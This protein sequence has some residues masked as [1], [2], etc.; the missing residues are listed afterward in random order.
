VLRRVA[1]R[2]KGH[3]LGHPTGRTVLLPVNTVPPCGAGTVLPWVTR[4]Y[5]GCCKNPCITG[6]HRTVMYPETTSVNYLLSPVQLSPA[7]PL[8]C[9]AVRLSLTPP[10][11]VRCPLDSVAPLSVR[12]VCCAARRPV[13][14]VT[15]PVALPPLSHGASP[16]TRR[17]TDV[18]LRHAAPIVS[19]YIVSPRSRSPRGEGLRFD[20]DVERV[21]SEAS[22]ECTNARADQGVSARTARGYQMPREGKGTSIQDKRRRPAQVVPV[23]PPPRSQ[24]ARG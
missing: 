17:A 4:F 1:R 5:G 2:D 11:H 14:C 9:A 22:H 24:T 18:M 23:E 6:L 16:A 20:V 21:S 10:P 12:A 7:P 15:P 8:T 3:P 19:H 13:P